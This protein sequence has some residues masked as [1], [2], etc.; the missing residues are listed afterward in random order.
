[1]HSLL[2]KNTKT[3]EDYNKDQISEATRYTYKTDE[4]VIMDSGL[5]P[6]HII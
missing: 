6:T 3:L 2:E 4:G 1:V 5:A